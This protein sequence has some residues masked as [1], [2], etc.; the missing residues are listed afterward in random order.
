LLVRRLELLRQAGRIGEM[1][2]VL[3]AAGGQVQESHALWAQK[4]QFHLRLGEHAEAAAALCAPVAQSVREQANAWTLRAQHAEAEWRLDYA[5][6]AYTEAL[7][8][9]PD[10]A[11]T[12]HEMSRICLL[13]LDLDQTRAHLREWFQL[14]RA[15]KRTRCESSNISQSH[16]GQLLDEFLLD[17]ACC[18]Q[19]TALQPFA[20]EERIEPMLRLV[21]QNPD[22]TP[23]AMCL[24]I[25]LRQAGRLSVW[26]GGDAL[27]PEVPARV[28]QFWTEP[29]PPKDVQALMRSWR[30]MNPAHAYCRFDDAGAQVFLAEHCAPAVLAAYRR[31]EHPAKK[32]D[33]F[34]LAWL[35]IEG[36]VYAD[37]DDRCLAP[38]SA[39]L[40]A[41]AGFVAYQEEYGTLGNNFL[42]ARPG[43]P[44]IGRALQWVTEAVN[45]G[46]TDMLWLATGPGLLTRAFCG[47]LA[48]APDPAEWLRSV[49]IL[50]RGELARFAAIHCWAQYKVTARHWSR[51]LF[52]RRT[53]LQG[54]A[55]RAH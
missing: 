39:T 29:D 35:F 45:R 43:H 1:Q 24:L 40:P 42:A 17:T 10:N 41:Q 23:A 7:H 21:A 47:T 48:E 25:A 30:E 33:I 12:H 54:V 5:H 16:I 14:Q 55:V 36:G 26:A 6:A 13:R 22:Y 15:S 38:L 11:W 52:R 46:D 51:S 34:R 37:S 44:L 31:A 49:A 2:G 53:L 32:A 50:E 19:L 9:H 20:P 8:L 18:R 3:Q 4:V 28:A 27:A